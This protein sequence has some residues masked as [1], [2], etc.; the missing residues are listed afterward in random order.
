MSKNLIYMIFNSKDTK[1]S[2]YNIMNPR[3]LYYSYRIENI[4]LVGD[5]L[6][7]LKYKNICIFKLFDFKNYL[8]LK[9][10]SFNSNYSYRNRQNLCDIKHPKLFL[11]A[12]E[13]NLRGR[14]KINN[15]RKLI[16]KL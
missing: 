7:L 1:N 3:L 5:K 14:L 11:K 2:L 4:M 16:V 6:F 15:F 8:S 12:L 13:W 9:R 10:A